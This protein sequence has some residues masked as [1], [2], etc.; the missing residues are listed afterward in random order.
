MSFSITKPYCANIEITG[1]CNYNCIHCFNRLNKQR[2][3]DMPLY[4]FKTIIDKLKRDGIFYYNLIG[5]EPLL[6]KKWHEI[7]KYVSFKKICYGLS[8]N[9]SLLNRNHV[10][11]LKEN[12]INHITL[13]LDGPSRIH[14]KIRS[15]RRAFS[16]LV[17][18]AKILREYKIPFAFQMTVN[19]INFSYIKET[20]KIAENMGGS[21]IRINFYKDFNKLSHESLI[22]LGGKILK[23]TI[24]TIEGIIKKNKGNSNFKINFEN[25]LAGSF[26][27]KICCGAGVHKVQIDPA[28]NVTPCRYLPINMG[29]LY[30]NSLSKILKNKIMNELAK[31]HTI[32]KN[33]C[34]NCITS[35]ICRGGCPAFI[36]NAYGNLTKK[37]PRC[38]EK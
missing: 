5:G 24:S 28:G 3:K 15:N 34:S 26:K 13:S 22:S 12:G 38:W 37:D 18:S 9:G 32:T 14:N 20:C 1:G 35:K 23:K 21:A 17:A 10:K 25:S 19:N 11:Y 2:V 7:I 29:N 30:T 6:H 4:K 33:G 36:Y 31:F 27:E 8:T 16:Q